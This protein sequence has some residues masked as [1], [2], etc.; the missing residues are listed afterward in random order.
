LDNEFWTDPNTAQGAKK[1]VKE[2]LKLFISS[3][4]SFNIIALL[5]ELNKILTKV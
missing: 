2:G 4:H 3:M 1:K 5:V